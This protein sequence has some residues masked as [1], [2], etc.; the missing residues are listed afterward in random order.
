MVPSDRFISILRVFLG[1]MSA[2]QIGWPATN[3]A[4]R[5]EYA[6]PARTLRVA[7]APPE[8]LPYSA[9]Y[10]ARRRGVG[11]PWAPAPA[12]GWMVA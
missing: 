11:E 6:N 4:P 5:C 3:V 9:R 2:P 1:D 8:A 10:L 7:R 12:K